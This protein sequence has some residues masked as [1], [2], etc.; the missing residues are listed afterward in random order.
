MTCH[1]N[2]GPDNYEQEK[3]RRLVRQRRRRRRVKKK[4][5]HVKD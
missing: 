3:A 5:V 4:K 1:Q 2:P